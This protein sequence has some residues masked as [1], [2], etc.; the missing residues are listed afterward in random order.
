MATPYPVRR[1]RRDH[2]CGEAVARARFAFFGRPFPDLKAAGWP[3]PIDGTDPRVLESLYRA[4]G[5]KVVSGEM[6]LAIL[7][8]LLDAGVAVDCLVRVDGGGYWVGHWVTAVRID[9]VRDR[10]RLMDPSVGWRWEGVESFLGSWQ[11]VNRSGAVYDRWGVAAT[12]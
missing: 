5:L 8:A 4:G 11:D 3:S 12:T 2:D 7:E 9:D 10:V 6:S 1:Q